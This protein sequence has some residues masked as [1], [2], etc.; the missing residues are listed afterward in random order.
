MALCV[1]GILPAAMLLVAA[2]R[3]IAAGLTVGSVKG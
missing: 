3:Y 1:V 2:Q